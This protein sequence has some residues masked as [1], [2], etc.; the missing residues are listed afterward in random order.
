MT[1]GWMLL[2]VAIVGGAIF[3]IAQSEAVESVSGF[4]GGDVL[5]EDAGL[6]INDNLEL[7]LRNGDSNTVEI[8]EVVVSDGSSEA[9]FRPVGSQSI[10]VGN[11][12]AVT[13]NG[14]VDGSGADDLEVTINYDSGNLEDLT[15]SG[16]VSGSL[17]LE[18]GEPVD[19]EEPDVGGGW[20]W[21]DGNSYFETDSEDGFYLM[22]YEARD[23]DGAVSEEEGEP[24]TSI[25][26]DDSV[27]EC[28]ALDEE[29]DDYDIHLVTN[30]E[31][32]TV[33]RQIEEQED[34]WAD[35]NIGSSVNEDGGLVRGWSADDNR[36]DDWDNS[37]PAPDS[38]SS[39]LYNVDADEG[40]SEGDELY[41]RTHVLGS[42][43][44][45]WDFSGN[46]WQ[47]VDVKEDGTSLDDGEILEGGGNGYLE[48][49]ASFVDPWSFN[50]ASDERFEIG[51]SN[52]DYGEE[53][54]LGYVWSTTSDDRVLRRGG[55]WNSGPR[56]GP[57]ASNSHRAASNSISP[58]GFRCSAVPVS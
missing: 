41:R 26:F 17:E 48:S 55:D 50:D 11:S 12:E 33:A 42:G 29:T 31:W 7:V 15:V 47:W 6:S 46:V 2:V 1:Y 45:V 5:V 21:V 44:V 58:T 38:T 27:A 56:A 18:G 20:S 39:N 40:S 13:V 14:V 52:E 19:L 28:E 4:S 3:S 53:Q 24:W 25:S 54:G 35:G 57:F 9:Y 43:D 37:D 30:R 23:D 8:N 10:G 32:M 16:S 36:G 49:S 51:S 34:N 22:T